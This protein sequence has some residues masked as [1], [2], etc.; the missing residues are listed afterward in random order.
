MRT[1]TKARTA[2]LDAQRSTAQSM[3]CC[4]SVSAC[5]AAMDRAVPLR[6]K[7]QNAGNASSKLVA[8]AA[9]KMIG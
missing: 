3:M 5:A 7:E 4:G 2:M 9:F 1:P 8:C 6:V